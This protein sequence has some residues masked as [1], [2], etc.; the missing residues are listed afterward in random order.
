MQSS[1]LSTEHKTT[2]HQT[3]H[4][5][6]IVRDTSQ[7]ILSVPG[8][9]IEEW[10]VQEHC[11]IKAHL[12]DKRSFSGDGLKKNWLD[13]YSITRQTFLLQLFMYICVTLDLI[14]FETKSLRPSQP[15]TVCNPVTQLR[16]I[17]RYKCRQWRTENCRQW[18]TERGLGGSNLSSEI[19]KA[20]Q[21]RAKL[22]WILKTVKNGWI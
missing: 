15:R 4:M 21:N 5:R 20:L 12:L 9:W 19:P 17:L 14:T 18:R 16:H 6:H 11:S 7:T 22:K 10:W 1:S 2:L 13:M 8:D 3:W